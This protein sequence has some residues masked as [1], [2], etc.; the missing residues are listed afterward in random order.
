MGGLFC[1]ALFASYAELAKWAVQSEASIYYYETDRVRSIVY[2]RV[3]SKEV[4]DTHTVPR[5]LSL[6]R[7]YS[8][9]L[10]YCI[11]VPDRR[12][13]SSISLLG[14]SHLSRSC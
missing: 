11:T 14:L 13:S 12:D 7:V 8:N 1:D 10:P 2:W 9:L 5:H 3:A 6:G 4:T